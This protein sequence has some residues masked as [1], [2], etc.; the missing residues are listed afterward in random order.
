M[1]TLHEQTADTTDEFAERIVGT[2]DAVGA[3]HLDLAEH[4]EGVP[5]RR[6]N[7]T[8]MTTVPFQALVLVESR[9]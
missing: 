4:P 1:T 9:R 5:R 6:G 3:D 8:A 7:V 2:I